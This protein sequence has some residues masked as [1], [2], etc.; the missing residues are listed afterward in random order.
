MEQHCYGHRRI[1]VRITSHLQKYLG[2][3][4]NL[5]LYRLSVHQIVF[6]LPFF[7]PKFYL[8]IKSVICW[9]MLI[10]FR[11]SENKR[12][13]FQISVT[14]GTLAFFWLTD[15][16]FF[17]ILILGANL[18]FIWCRTSDAGF[19]QSLLAQAHLISSHL[20]LLCFADIMPLTN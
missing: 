13:V 8:C 11:M 18:S 2:S 19:I 16:L 3:F 17:H 15:F 12:F 4:H 9:I 7:C 5:S 20:A 10:H 1:Q 6:F 14:S